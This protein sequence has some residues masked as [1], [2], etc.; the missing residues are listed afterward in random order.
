MIVPYPFT[1]AIFLYGEPI[2]VPRD[3][4]LEEM[5]ARVEHAMNQLAD[6]AEREFD[7]LWEETGMRHGA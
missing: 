4:D 1:R 2:F 6:R 3:A 7:E 5:R